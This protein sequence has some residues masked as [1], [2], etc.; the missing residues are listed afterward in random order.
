MAGGSYLVARRIR[1]HIEVWDRTPLMEQEQVIGRDKKVGAPLGGVNEHDEPDFAARGTDGQ[2]RIPATAH[3]RLAH[4]S[5]LGGVRIL[6]RGYTFTDG[7]DGQGH[8]D[9]G[10]FF[11][12]YVRDAHRQF[13]PM[14]RALARSDGLNEYIEHTG[15]ALFAV[16]PGLGPD[17]DWGRQLFG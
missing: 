3:V 2:P 9:A 13:V 14:Q 12:A 5:A 10:L 7:T 15:S 17:D 6:R 1:M 8:L 16:P 11:L 4:H